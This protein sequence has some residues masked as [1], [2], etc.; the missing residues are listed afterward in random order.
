MRRIPC[1]WLL[2]SV[3]V[4]ICVRRV[5]SSDTG[6]AGAAD[7]AGVVVAV[8][9]ALSDVGAADGAACDAGR[10]GG[11]INPEAAPLDAGIAVV[12]FGLLLIVVG[13]E[14]VRW[15]ERRHAHKEQGAMARVVIGRRLYIPAPGGVMTLHPLEL[16]L[17]TSSNARTHGLLVRNS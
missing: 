1:K 7:A 12:G 17:N 13:G 15:F 4:C 9:L 5:V 14:G 16:G 3:R 8:V 11:G 10:G 6:V 2:N